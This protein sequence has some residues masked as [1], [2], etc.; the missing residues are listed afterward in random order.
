MAGAMSGRSNYPEGL[1]H[2]ASLIAEAAEEQGCQ[3]EVA[4]A[5]SRGAIERFRK[6]WGGAQFYVPKML[7]AE[8]ALMHASIFSAWNSGE[9]PAQ[10]ARR[11]GK[12]LQ[13][14]YDIIRE[15]RRTAKSQMKG[16]FDDL[17]S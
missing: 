1:S 14:I 13:H 17:N 15:Q 4:E 16:L 3:P 11:F 2:L 10:L 8:V 7:N 12:S 9:E 5:V 6:D